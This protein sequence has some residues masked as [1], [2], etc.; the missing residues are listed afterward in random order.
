[1]AGAL[2]VGGTAAGATAGTAGASGALDSP[3]GA[4]SKGGSDSGTSGE[5]S[6]SGQD[7]GGAAAGGVANCRTRHVAVPVAA[8]A[9]IGAAEPQVNHGDEAELLVLGGA[10]E[11]RAL[12]SFSLP[13]ADASEVL[14][15]AALVLTLTQPVD[16]GAEPA[17]FNLHSLDVAF[18]ENRVTWLNYGSGGS[19]KWAMPGGDF[20]ASFGTGELSSS[21]PA[22]RVDSTA[23]VAAAYARQEAELNLLLREVRVAGA[24]PVF[25]FE[26]KEGAVAAIPAL[27]LEFCPR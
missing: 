5:S 2:L 23:L 21:D 7:S 9:W 15:R 18:V 25:G 17:F 8:D 14:A 10:S 11:Q 24:G 13:A 3:G 4:E 19:R 20:G 16:L 27:D 26:T 1:M 6:T 12:F 22:L